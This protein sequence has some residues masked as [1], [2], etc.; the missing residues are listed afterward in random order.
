MVKR[1][2]SEKEREIAEALRFI[3][4]MKESDAFKNLIIRGF[5]EEK[6]R[7]LLEE[8]FK[9]GSEKFDSKED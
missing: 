5:V 3:K 9:T 4:S 7:L 6:E 2:G 1:K 8:F